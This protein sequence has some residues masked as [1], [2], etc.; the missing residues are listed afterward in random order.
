MDHPLLK[1]R[2]RGLRAAGTAAVFFAV[3]GLLCSCIPFDDPLEEIDPA[4][5]H[6][7][8]FV[9]LPAAENFPVA[10]GHILESFG[11]YACSNCPGAEAKLEPYLDSALPGH[12]PRLVIVNYHV[13]FPGAPA[14]PWI[15]SATQARNDQFGFTSLPQ[16]KMNGANAPYGIREKEV[17]Y[18]QGEYDSLIRRLRIEDTLTWLDL[19]LDTAASRYDSASRRMNVRFTAYNRGLTAQPALSF[20]VLAVK[21]KAVVIPIYPNHP[22]GVIV[23]ETTEQDSAGSLMVLSAMPPLTAKSYRVQLQIPL[24]TERNPAP[25]IPENP[26]HYAIVLFAKDATGKVKNVVSWRFSPE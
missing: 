4:L 18:A 24:E 6:D 11:A 2:Y 20:R 22:W 13:N 10:R 15:T 7:S 14:D 8:S 21:N 26:A 9:Y 1:K 5:I 16:V 12:V 3:T 17:R 23:A 19:R 25:A